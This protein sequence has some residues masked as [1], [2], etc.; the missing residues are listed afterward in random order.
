MN[1]VLSL[2]SETWEM[3]R[4][5][6]FAIIIRIWGE[7]HGN[8]FQYSCLK[9]STDSRSLLQSIGLQ[10]V[11]HGWSDLAHTW[12]HYP[13]PW[14]K[15]M[16]TH[17]SILAWEIH[18]QRSLAGYSPWGRKVRHNLATTPPSTVRI[19]RTK[20]MEA[21]ISCNNCVGPQRSPMYDFLIR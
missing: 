6:I 14:E 16:A 1:T 21:D 18:E 7:G 10:R 17:S 13:L 9:N 3:K 20:L 5:S 8:P 4:H 2:D 19:W 11:R 15:E 12:A